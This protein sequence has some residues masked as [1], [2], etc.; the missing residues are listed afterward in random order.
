MALR[1]EKASSLESP[2]TKLL[3]VYRG[4]NVVPLKFS[5]TGEFCFWRLGR[6]GAVEG[7]PRA[8]ICLDPF[9]WKVIVKS[10]P[11]TSLTACLI[12][13]IKRVSRYSTVKAFGTDT[14]NRV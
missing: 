10:S 6:L 1:A 8:V 12:S 2:T 5:V 9:A 13:P 4:L 3:K 7:S 14:N 11:A